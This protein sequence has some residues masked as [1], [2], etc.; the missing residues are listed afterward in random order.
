MVLVFTSRRVAP[1]LLSW[2][3]WQALREGDEVLAG[4]SEHPQVPA[5]RDAGIRVGVLP[6]ESAPERADMLV[7][8]AGAGRWMVW[9]ADVDGDDGDSGDTALL[10]AL[11]DA[12]SRAP[13]AAPDVE[14]VHGSYDM[15]GARLLDL[16]A[17]MD[18]LRSPGGC[19]WDRE[20]THVSLAPHLLEEAYE[21]VEA[22]ETGDLAALPEELG[23]VLLQ[24]AFH[25][26]VAEERAD[27]AGF[28][29]DD[30]ARE[31]VDKLVRRH[32]HVF[33]DVEVSGADEVKANWDRIKAAER[34]GQR[35]AASVVD[36]VPVAQPALSLA[37]QLQRRAER[38]GLS[39]DVASFG[40][41][42]G[43]ELFALVARAR[44]QGEDPETLLRHTARAFRDRLVE[45]EH[46]AS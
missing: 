43:G 20:Q 12:A 2:P 1:G 42:L 22:V 3:A 39:D 46:A 9:L 4:T 8:R 28:T 29:I 37:A 41:D 44:A 24:V 33:G 13:D 38:A 31:I 30:V 26:R 10:R 45:R 14:V 21:A 27:G 40:E 17:T 35:G 6:A 34:G 7:D 36:G 19:P 18:R 25:A 15:P 23:D 32:P 5:V 16:V 11:E